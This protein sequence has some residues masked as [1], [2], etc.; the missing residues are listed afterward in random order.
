MPCKGRD[1]ADHQLKRIVRSSFLIRINFNSLFDRYIQYM[2]IN[3]MRI[4]WDP[5]KAKANFRKHRVRFPDAESVLFDPMALTR[6]DEKLYDEQ[7]F[8]TIGTDSMNRI[9]VV[10]YSYSGEDIRLISA[11]RATPRERKSYEKRIRF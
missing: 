11:R 4:L 2:Y 6:E 8:V 1:T 7:R 3:N 9:V 10:V 5:E